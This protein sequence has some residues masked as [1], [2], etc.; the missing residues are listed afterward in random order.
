[1]IASVRGLIVL[2]AVAV[3]LAV[4]VFAVEPTPA[5][6][7]ESRTLGAPDKIESFMVTPAGKEPVTVT[8]ERDGWRII[9]EARNANA[10][11]ATVDALLA[12]LRG[13]KWHRRANPE[14]AAP[15]LGELQ[16]GDLRIGVGRTLPG[17]DQAWLVIRGHALLVDGW[18]ARA[19]LP[20]PLALRVRRPLADVGGKHIGVGEV[21]LEGREQRA[22]FIRW[23]SEATYGELTR[24]LGEVE[25]VALDGTPATPGPAIT[26]ADDEIREAGTCA[27]GR[28][29]VT[30]NIGR[31]CVERAQWQAAL[32]AFEPLRLAGAESIVDTRPAPFTVAT[33]R[34][35]SGETLNVAGKPVLDSG[36]VVD[37]TR[38]SEL[39]TALATPATIVARPAGASPGTKLE[40]RAV[41]DSHV[42]LELY[43][44]VVAR[45]GESFALQPAPE[46]MAILKRPPAALRESVLWRED[47]ITI[48]SL[49]LD[50]VT[51][52]RGAVLGE[53]SRIPTG[54]VDAAVVDAVVETVATLEGPSGPPPARVAHRLTLRFTP[55][56]GAAHTHKLELGAP[57]ATSCSARV[58]GKPVQLDAEDV[59]LCAAVAA[60]AALR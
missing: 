30:A 57:T 26:V 11:V 46:Q 13:A 48:T 55:P 33:V 18:V 27:N 34:F 9:E 42:T 37:V 41:D 16:I 53:W 1:M 14:V 32:A 45:E 2:A 25:Y 38:V 17:T 43:A 29:F 49:E 54:S 39:V 28:I 7:S 10:D 5:T 12:A 15:L 31:G 21:R 51:Y 44:N 58:D 56:A 23:I 47:P 3:A 52:S 59:P 24:V 35:A 4:L 8:K 36:G 19:L 20:D 50:G 22:P 6:V 60:L 40:L